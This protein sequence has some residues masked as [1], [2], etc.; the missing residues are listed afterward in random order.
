MVASKRRPFSN[1]MLRM[2]ALRATWTMMLLVLAAG[3]C[4][5]EHVAAIPR[6]VRCLPQPSSGNNQDLQENQGMEAF[7]AD[8]QLVLAVS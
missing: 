8:R 4:I 7:S 2:A 3:L 6:S 1:A 5:A